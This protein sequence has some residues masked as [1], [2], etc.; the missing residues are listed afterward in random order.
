MDA[1]ASR[2]VQ[3]DAEGLQTC[4]LHRHGMCLPNVLTLL[5]HID[6]MSG[7]VSNALN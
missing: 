4:F 2:D 7:P 6:S 5:S 1:W 3:Y